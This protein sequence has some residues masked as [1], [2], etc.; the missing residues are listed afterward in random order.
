MTANHTSMIGPNAPP[1]FA[2]PNL[3]TENSKTRTTTAAGMT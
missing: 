1:I 2:V 3:W